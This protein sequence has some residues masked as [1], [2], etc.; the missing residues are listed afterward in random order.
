MAQTP[1]NQFF[2]AIIQ[3]QALQAH[4]QAASDIQTCV[5]LAEAQGYLFTAKE[6]Q[7]ELS[8]LS[9]EEVAE[10]VNPGIAP[11]LHIEPH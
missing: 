5:N 2:A 3:N 4:C 9:K 8:K 10:L 1:I 7:A 11:R 6:L